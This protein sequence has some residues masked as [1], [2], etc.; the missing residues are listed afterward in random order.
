MARRQGPIR[1]ARAAR[2]RTAWI[3]ARFDDSIENSLFVTDQALFVPLEDEQAATIV[4]IVG[5]VYM[6]PTVDNFTLCSW[7][8]YKAGSGSDGDLQMDP[9]SA[10]DQESEHWMHLRSTWYS[11]AASSSLGADFDGLAQRVDIKVMRKIEE[12]DGIK[13]SFNAQS[14]GVAQSYFHAVNLRILLKLT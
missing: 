7:G 13:I 11:R 2:R 12:G 1:R 4:R 5:S 3:S 9:T 8:I 14:G 10:L 6:R